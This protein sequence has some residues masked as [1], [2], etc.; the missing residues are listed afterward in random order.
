MAEYRSGDNITPEV[1]GHLMAALDQVPGPE[2]VRRVAPPAPEGQRWPDG[3]GK[4]HHPKERETRPDRVGHG[5]AVNAVHRTGR[6]E[7]PHSS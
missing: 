2:P 7:M 3:S 5:A 6:P 4:H 1:A